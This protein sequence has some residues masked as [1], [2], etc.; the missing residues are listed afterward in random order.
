MTKIKIFRYIEVLDCFT[1]NED[2]KSLANKLGF[3]EWESFAWIGRYFCLDNDYGEHWFDNWDAREFASSRANELGIDTDS[4]L[5]IDPERFKNDKDGPCH[6]AA[7]RKLFWT[8]VLMSLELSLDVIINEAVKN[9]L[10]NS[11]SEDFVHD[12]NDRIEVVRNAYR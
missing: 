9:N 4:L 6:S 11:G 10:E 8:N 5:F 2:Y 12:L 3:E 7:E 1:L